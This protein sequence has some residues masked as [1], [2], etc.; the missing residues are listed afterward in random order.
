MIIRDENN[1]MGRFLRA[2]ATSD[3]PALE[4]YSL[5]ITNIGFLIAQGTN[6][7]ILI[8]IPVIFGSI[9]LTP[10]ITILLA[11]F[12]YFLSYRL[13]AVHHYLAGRFLFSASLLLSVSSLVIYFGTASYSHFLFLPIGIGALMIWPQNR[14]AQ[15]LLASLAF[16][17]FLVATAS[18]HPG[19]LTATQADLLQGA[20]IPLFN[21]SLAFVVTFI[22]VLYLVI[23]SEEMQKRLDGLRLTA[24]DKATQREKQLLSTLNAL[25]LARD[26]ETGNHVIRTQLYVRTLA[27][28]LLSLGV[29][30]ERLNADT[31]DLLFRA[32]PLHDVGK[33]GIPDKILLKPGKLDEAQWEVM[34]TH[35]TIGE[36]ILASAIAQERAEGPRDEMDVMAVGMNIAG[37]HHE[38]WDGSG[39]PRGL[40]EE[41]I[42]LEARIMAVADV[43]DALTSERP[44]KPKWTSEQALEYIVAGAG[45]RFDPAVVDALYLEQ[46][47]FKEISISYADPPQ[48]DR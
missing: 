43:Y 13:I 19:F 30:T 14:P 47:R 10:T 7:V 41:Q 25:S 39:Y 38:C 32:A 29:Y 31:I 18:N 37:G 24:L 12:L 9:Y 1:W 15:I 8:G 40:R 22:V 3:M 28:R 36:S 16:L 11:I 5:L 20:R 21:V 48:A 35:T 23:G 33:I 45:T 2:G 17:A 6:L 44:Y 4:Q 26:Y 27:H 34:K 46:D 42:P